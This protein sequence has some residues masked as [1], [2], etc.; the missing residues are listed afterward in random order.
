MPSSRLSYS[1]KNFINLYFFDISAE[2]IKA[3]KGIANTIPILDDRPL[4]VSR[5]TKAVENR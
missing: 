2:E 3:V 4:M 1:Q 5:A